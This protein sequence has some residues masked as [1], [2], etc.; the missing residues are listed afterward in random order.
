[1][2]NYLRQKGKLDSKL[3]L[4]GSKPLLKPL[5]CQCGEVHYQ[6]RHNSKPMGT[7]NLNKVIEQNYRNREETNSRPN[8]SVMLLGKLRNQGS[9]SGSF[10][11]P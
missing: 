6:D 5:K 3:D 7:L 11:S 8:Q 1:M 4:L 2:T 10:R 9:N